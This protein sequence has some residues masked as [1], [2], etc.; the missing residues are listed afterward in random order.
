LDRR[1]PFS[2]K[3]LTRQIKGTLEAV[4]PPI[5]VEGEISDLRSASSGHLY[6]SLKD[7]EARIRAVMFRREVGKLPFIPS[8]GMRTIVLARL[9]VYEARG[10]YQLLVEDME[11]RGIGA[12]HRAMEQLRIRLEAE[13]IFSPKRKRG[14]PLFPVCV[15]IVT[16][17]SGAAVRDILKILRER[18]APVRVMISPALV[19]GKEAPQS[20]IDAL[21]AL[22]RQ[23][24]ADVIIIGRGGGSPE[25]LLPFS[26]EKVVRAVADCPV[27]IISAV[28]H[29][30]DISLSDLAA[31]ASAPTP[32]VAA[33]MVAAGR[34]EILEQ[35]RFLETR[36]RSGISHVLRDGREQLLTVGSR[37]IHPRH[38]LEQG[39]MRLDDLSFRLGSHV[40][41]RLGQFRADLTR[42]SGLLRSLGPQAVLDRGY[43]V[44]L[45]G[46]GSIVR[47]PA[48]VSTGEGLDLRVA[49]GRLKVKVEGGKGKG[50]V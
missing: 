3:E 26:E 39:R 24:E 30:I 19:Q 23:G 18:D 14:L 21:D 4:F 37:L 44:V 11:P 38:L 2:V 8:D 35:F 34:E 32:S 29:E 50:E 17:A 47:S 10:D 46:D 22:I 25:D 33:E 6:F 42:L 45:K 27:P 13:G 9:T 15:G 7:D 43:A 36:L 40:R 48:Q 41:A 1:H 16:S 28:G 12:L 20:L 5:W 31:D 49:E